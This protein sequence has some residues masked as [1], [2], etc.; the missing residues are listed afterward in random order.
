MNRLGKYKESLE[1]FVKNKSCL[2]TNFD[3]KHAD[4][5]FNMIKKN[6]KLLSIVLLT[7]MNNQT[8]KKKISS[9][10][11]YAASCIEYINVIMDIID[12]KSLHVKNIGNI[13]EYNKCIIHLLSS[14]NKS[15]CKN[16]DS[17]KMHYTD[18]ITVNSFLDI[19][20]LYNNNITF[21]N[22]LSNMSMDI[23]D[24]KLNNDVYKW[25]VL[26]KPALEKKYSGLL[27]INDKSFAKYIESKIEKLCELAFCF[28]WLLGCGDNTELH[29]VKIMS[30][31]FS[32][33]YKLFIDFTNI[34]NDIISSS[35]ICCNYVVNY[36]LHASY[37]LFMKNKQKF[38]EIA[39]ILDSYTMTI[40]E[41]IHHMESLVEQ[42]IDTTFPDLSSNLTSKT[43]NT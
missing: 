37:D 20:E 15:I 3:T 30:K 14:A 38:I 29:M 36:G 5:I 17:V 10:G 35:N 43:N 2:Y 23:T 6:N 12:N 7:I 24:E 4:Y 26:G 34:D 16:I 28:G 40:K 31:H 9:Q 39:M 1:K 19:M 32:L 18:Q 25:Y 11:Y 41:I 33:M 13:D 22:I 21:T 8:K 42:F 27:K